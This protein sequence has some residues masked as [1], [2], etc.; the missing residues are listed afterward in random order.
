MTTLC[1]KTEGETELVLILHF[2][3]KEILEGSLRHDVK[4]GKCVDREWSV[5][6]HL[7]LDLGSR[8]LGW[9]PRQGV[10]WSNVVTKKVDHSIKIS[11]VSVRAKTHKVSGTKITY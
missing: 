2:L 9:V 8:G 6:P 4:G 11:I 7:N 3:I 10:R 5:V 1:N